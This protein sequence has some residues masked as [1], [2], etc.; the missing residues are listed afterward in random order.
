MAALSAILC[1][2][3]LRNSEPAPV[4]TAT[5]KTNCRLYLILEAITG[6]ATAA[7]LA[8]ALGAANIAS[9]LLVPPDANNAQ[10]QCIFIKERPGV[11]G[12]SHR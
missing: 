7:R 10:W 12:P 6:E 11:I 8:A 5:K 2:K 4:I 3:P 9:V 1:Q